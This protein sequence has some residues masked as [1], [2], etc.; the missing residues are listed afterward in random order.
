MFTRRLRTVNPKGDLLDRTRGQLREPP[1]GNVLATIAEI[2][3]INEAGDATRE[4]VLEKIQ[5]MQ[6]TYDTVNESLCRIEKY[7]HKLASM[8]EEWRGNEKLPDH[9]LSASN[10]LERAGDEVR[11]LKEDLTSVRGSLEAKQEEVRQLRSRLSKAENCRI[12]ERVSIMKT[13]L[14]DESEPRRRASE[15][16]ITA[17]EESERVRV[18]L[19]KEVIKLKSIV[20][21][22]QNISVRDNEGKSSI[23]AEVSRLEEI[24]RQLIR[25][26]TQPH[27]VHFP[28]EP[29]GTRSNK[30]NVCFDSLS[31]TFHRE[32]E[33]ESNEPNY[34]VR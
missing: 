5:S 6:R 14:V 12:L 30:V 34:T 3:G 11:C 25:S 28:H 22:A 15:T 16:L 32:L 23:F 2:L 27:G 17:Y 21:S 26:T 8:I 4:Q 13:S 1:E 18:T 10:V 29:I 31:E 7:E 9:I 20:E 33:R 24:N 19:E